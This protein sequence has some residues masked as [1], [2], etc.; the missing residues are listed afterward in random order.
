MLGSRL[1]PVPG[2]CPAKCP[3]RVRST[4]AAPAG[5]G[6]ANRC[7]LEGLRPQGIGVFPRRGRGSWA[8]WWLPRVGGGRN[9]SSVSYPRPTTMP[10]W[11]NWQTRQPQDLVPSR[12]CK[13]ES[14]RGHAG[15][16]D[17]RCA[18]LAKP[19]PLSGWGGGVRVCSSAGESARLKSGRSQVRLLPDP[20][21]LYGDRAARGGRHL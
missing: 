6:C 20:R 1:A 9:A 15:T 8:S 17:C 12:A 19:P 18:V 14:C 11:R 16:V 3:V 4:H 13:F 7:S 21:L 2:K 10:P 5:I